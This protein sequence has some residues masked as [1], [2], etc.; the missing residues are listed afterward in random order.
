MVAPVD[1]FTQDD[2]AKSCLAKHS[3]A[4]TKRQNYMYLK[5]CSFCSGKTYIKPK[6]CPA[7]GEICS[8]CR[9]LTYFEFMCFAKKNNLTA[10]TNQTWST[11]L[12]HNRLLFGLASLKINNMFFYNVF[13]AAKINDVLMTAL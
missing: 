13:I 4:V 2:D 7:F 8:Y 12:S 5:N 3:P 9:K 6:D 11:I 1:N 10:E